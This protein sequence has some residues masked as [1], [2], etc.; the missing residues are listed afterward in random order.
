MIVSLAARVLFGGRRPFRQDGMACVD[1]LQPPLHVFGDE[2]IP[3]AGP[4][5]ILHN[6]Y[7]RP[8]FNAWW[9]ALALA[10]AVP[11]EIHFV[12]TGELTFP[13]KW[14]APAGMA[15]SRWL[16]RRISQVYGFTTMPPIPPRPQDVQAR[17]LSV[18][19]TLEYGQNHPE[20]LLS[21]APEGGDQPGGVLNWPPA[22]TGRFMALLTSAGRPVTPVGVYEEEGRLCLHFG[23]SFRLELPTRLPA[24][25]KDRQAA[26]IA[27]SAI[28]AQLPER[29]RGE[30][31]S[32]QFR[33]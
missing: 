29:L 19:R 33:Y 5:L 8:G 15:G 13:G 3:S 1:R 22:G 12:M 2:N 30:F 32:Y 31:N 25:E 26:E 14:Y 18:R 7:Y 21:L 20:S 9:M 17:A 16:L 10:A 11:Q 4:G 23:K 6:H 28:A 24:P 27:M